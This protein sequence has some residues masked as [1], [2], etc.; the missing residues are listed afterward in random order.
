MQNLNIA[1][2]ANG[3]LVEQVDT[4]IKRVLANIIDPNTDPLKK[5][6]IT[7]T[8]EF[9]PSEDRDI[10]DVSFST[11]STLIPA[12]PISTR[13]VFEKD[14]DGKIL[15]EE[16]GRGALKGQAQIDYETGEVLEPKTMSR[17]V[18]LK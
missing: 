18:N 13:I 2:I 16:L 14:N 3:A 8:L 11:K 17:V 9:K 15:L 1:N 12:K 5:R 7:V 10:S 6:K 4:E